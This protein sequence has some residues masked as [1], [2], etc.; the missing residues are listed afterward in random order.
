VTDG[1]ATTHNHS[2]AVSRVGTVGTKVEVRTRFDG[3]WSQ[4]FE[5]ADVEDDGYRIKRMTD[6]TVLPSLFHRHEVRRERRRAT[7]WI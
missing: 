7:W 2:N 5:I 4:G 3:T 6:G 1:D